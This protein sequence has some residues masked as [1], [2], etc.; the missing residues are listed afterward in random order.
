[1][2]FAANY[3]VS[4][5]T[6]LEAVDGYRAAFRPS[7]VLDAPYVSVS[8]DVV[9][10]DT[11]EKARE[12]ATGYGLWVRSIRTAEGAIQ[13]PTPAEARR[14]AWSDSDRELVAD[15]IDTQFTGTPG[16]VADQM[17]QLR[18]ATEAD[19][20]IITTITHDHVDRV[21]SYQLLAEEWAR[22]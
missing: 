6:V 21:R 16:Q 15:R 13:F 10:A 17:E 5:A 7:A 11:E 3:H 22:R 4:P 18:D 20:L 12:L 2:R 8:A 19:E 1:L 14:H 9:V